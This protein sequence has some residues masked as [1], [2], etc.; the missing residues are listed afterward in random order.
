MKKLSIGAFLFAVLAAAVS[1]S[2]PHVPAAA[3]AAP[4]A[5]AGDGPGLTLTIL[6]VNDVHGQT[7]PHLSGGK[8]IG[9]YSRL[10]TLVAKARGAGDANLVLLLH[11]GDELSK[12]D[13]LTRKTLGA[14]NFQLMNFLRFDAW[15]PGNGDYYDGLPVLRRLIAEANFPTLTANVTVKG[16][17]NC[18]AQPYVIKQMGPIKVALFGLCT[19][20]QEN[21]NVSGLVA[22][23]PVETAKKLV[24]E[25]RK[26]ADVVIAVTHLGYLE[27]VKLAQNVPGIDLIVGGHSHTV[28]DEGQ[29][30]PGPDEKTV[31]IVQTGWQL[32]YLGTVELKMKSAGG[33]WSAASATAKLT[34]ID[35]GVQEDPAVKA[36][37]ARLWEATS[38]PAAPVRKPV[39]VGA[40]K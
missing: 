1:L 32:E 13:A 23:D 22:A 10:S 15:T 34:P 26:K 17:G 8:N 37:I 29:S 36:M 2:L 14:A 7:Q 20:Y 11:A 30:V 27:D 25:L 21:Q 9:G 31:L 5:P 35:A 28:L 3:P 24:P 4:G 12:S 6:H 33:R 18:V 39:P 16:D 19:V 40:G 38:Q